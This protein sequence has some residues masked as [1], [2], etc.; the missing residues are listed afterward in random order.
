MQVKLYAT[1]R[2]L[3]GTRQVEIPVGA[4]EPIQAVLRRL[5]AERPA[6]APEI[7]ADPDQTE[8]LPYVAVYINGRNIL[9]LEGLATPIQGHEEV[10]IFPPLAGG[11]NHAG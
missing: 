5:V 3:A 10:A 4:G 6:L 8:L 7:F 9:H 1:L 11:E 2:A